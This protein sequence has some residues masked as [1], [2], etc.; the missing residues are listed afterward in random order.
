MRL[1]ALDTAT[2]FCS[3]AFCDG[4]QRFSRG[5]E[6]PRQHAQLVLPFVQDILNQA[7]ISLSQV[8]ALVLGCGPGSFTG[9]RIAAGIGQGLAFSQNIPLVGISSLQALAQ[10]AY[11]VH[12]VRQVVA[13]ID[14]RMGEVYCGVYRLTGQLMQA[15]GAEQVVAPAQLQATEL[16][17]PLPT[18]TGELWYGVGSGFAAYPELAQQLSAI[19]LTDI[20]FPRAED[21]LDL[22]RAA[23]IAGKG[24]AAKDYDVHY[25]RNEVTWQKL[26]G[27]N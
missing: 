14:A 17:A 9:V 3:V 11:L 12:G 25:V 10:Q 15:C 27:R 1:L 5:Q 2:E 13:A 21:M 22:G 18:P 16:L 20:C 23:L 4:V 6:A 8:D 24:I 26:P 19:P 7:Q